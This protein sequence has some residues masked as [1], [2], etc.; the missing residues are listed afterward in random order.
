MHAVSRS[1]VVYSMSRLSNLWIT[2]CWRGKCRLY[3]LVWCHA[4]RGGMY[5]R[6][7]DG[8]RLAYTITC[9]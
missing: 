4:R 7:L 1:V 6:K 2:L 9:R 8:H 3:I 5:C